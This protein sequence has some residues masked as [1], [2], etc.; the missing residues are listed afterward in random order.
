MAL[1][2]VQLVVLLMAC[3][4]LFTSQSKAYTINECNYRG[5]C[6]TAADCKVPCEDPKFPPGTIVLVNY[7]QKI[8]TSNVVSHEN[9]QCGTLT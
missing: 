8:T 2:K 7:H 4:L 1:S 9:E 3:F 5:K 6:N